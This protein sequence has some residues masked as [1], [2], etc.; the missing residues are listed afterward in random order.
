MNDTRRWELYPSLASC[1][2]ARCGRTDA[3]AHTASLG[4]AVLELP[5]T[6][7]GLGNRAIAAQDL[8]YGGVTSRVEPTLH[9][10]LVQRDEAATLTFIGCRRQQ[11]GYG[12][13][14]LE[15][16]VLLVAGDELSSSPLWAEKSQM[17]RFALFAFLPRALSFFS[18]LLPLLCVLGGLAIDLFLLLFRARRAL[19]LATSL[20]A[21]PSSDVGTQ[22]SIR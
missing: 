10:F 21:L 8:T 18:L 2:R 5:T 3:A 11:L 22:A 15:R 6:G 13:G 1:E 12:I 14:A 20:L 7:A 19:R 17:R 9:G 16:C 4:A